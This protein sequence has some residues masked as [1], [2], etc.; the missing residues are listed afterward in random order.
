MGA[1][2]DLRWRVTTVLETASQCPNGVAMVHTRHSFLNMLVATLTIGIYTPMHIIVTCAQGGSTSASVDLPEV[3][4]DEGA[5]ATQREESFREAVE[6]S[7]KTGSDVLLR[8]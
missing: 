4:I 6:I 8:F 3:R 5:T 7:L 2:L 1:V